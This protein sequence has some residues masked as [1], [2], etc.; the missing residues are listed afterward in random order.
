MPPFFPL[1]GLDIA[2]CCTAFDFPILA[3]L[4]LSMTPGGS[5]IHEPPAERRETGIERSSHLSASNHSDV[6]ELRPEPRLS[7]FTGQS[8][9]DCTTFPPTL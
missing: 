5:Q 3:H 1:T 7:A 4:I 6:T 9:R 8:L 2:M